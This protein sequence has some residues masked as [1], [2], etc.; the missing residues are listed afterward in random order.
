ME[1]PA[2]TDPTRPTGD[3]PSD[4]SLPDDREIPLARDLTETVIAFVHDRVTPI[5][6]WVTWTGG[7]PALVL[8][9]VTETL[10]SIADGLEPADA[11]ARTGG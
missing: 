7:D 2:M 1:V 10:R 6:E 11:D 3:A 5:V 4:P 9:V 8:I